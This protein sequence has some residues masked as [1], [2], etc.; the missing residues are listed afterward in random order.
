M[1]P[2]LPLAST[3]ARAVPYRHVSAGRA[4]APLPSVGSMPAEPQQLDHFWT[5]DLLICQR[6]FVAGGGGAAGAH[7]SPHDSMHVPLQTAHHARSVQWL[8]ACMMA[9]L[10]APCCLPEAALHLRQPCMP[11]AMMCAGVERPRRGLR[12]LVMQRRRGYAV[13]MSDFGT[14]T[15]HGRAAE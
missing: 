1:P 8:T 15:M 14:F 4:A 2:R 10:T 12:A 5:R 11:A 9:A 6:F 7:T 3:A 13:L